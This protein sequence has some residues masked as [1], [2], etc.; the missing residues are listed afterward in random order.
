MVEEYTLKIKEIVNETKNVKTFKFDTSSEKIDFKPGQFFMF[1]FKEDEKL[2]RAYSI[3]SSPTQKSLDITLNLVG[4]FTKKLFEAKVGDEVIAQGPFGKFFFDESMKQNL[5]L[6]GGGTGITPLMSIAKY[7]QDKNLNNK[8]NLLYSVK[9]PKD[10][11]YED[12]IR[13]LNKD[14]FDF[15]SIITITRPEEGDEWQGRSGRIDKELLEQNIKNIKYDLFF[16]CGS[17]EF[18]RSIISMLEE[19]GASK[20]QIKADI[21]GE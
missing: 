19:L 13:E 5:L 18:S 7:W 17:N 20:E 1:R 21:W 3:A 10:I 14:N 11:I 2:K 6:V 8:L 15:D 12:K 16:I 4:V 9:T